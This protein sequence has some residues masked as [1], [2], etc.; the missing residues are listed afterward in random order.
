MMRLDSL[1]IKNYR[2]LEN[3]RL[4]FTGPITILIGPNNVGKSNI[5]DALLFIQTAVSNLAVAIGQR[6]GFLRIA[7]G[8][9]PANT[10]GFDLGLSAPE[11]PKLEYSVSF[12]GSG[13]LQERVVRAGSP[14]YEAKASPG[15]MMVTQGVSFPRNGSLLILR[16]PEVEPI[17]QFL[18]GVVQV[19]P[20]R[21]VSIQSPIG[22]TKTIQPTGLDLAQVL[23]YHY[24]GDQEGFAAFQ[25]AASK[26]LPE[27]DIIETPIVGPAATTVQLRLKYDRTKYD[28]SEISSGIKGILVLL[29]AA[30]FSSRGS[31]I[32]IEEPENHIHPAAQKALCSVLKEVATTQ[33]KQFILTTH[34]DSVLGQFDPDHCYFV[35]RTESG[36]S[37][38]PLDKMDAYTIGERLGVERGLLLQVLGR[39]QQ[40][41]V[42]CEGR[43]DTKVIESLCRENDLADAVL[44]AR[45]SGGGWKEIVD[46]AADLRDALKRFRI[47]SSVFV[48]LDNDGESQAKLAYLQSKG[49]GEETAHV[50]FQKEIESYLALPATLATLSRKSLDEIQQV[51]RSAPGSGKARLHWILDRLGIADIP[52]SVIVTNA[53]RQTTPEI[54]EEFQKIVAKL[55]A[56]VGST[57]P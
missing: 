31:L 57:A 20:F 46:S 6:R 51:I 16:T 23:H 26:V 27:L 8:Q 21:N 45:A 17:V 10:I 33:D 18:S 4:D 3:I 55:R 49:F 53:A 52:P 34:S 7:R 40:I 28:L 9:N 43:T 14:I 12:D 41:V 32:L 24:N 39:A 35:D 56:L 54:P 29:A 25:A 36:S 30:H 42:I 19:D 11:Q 22:P 44:P 48:L 15:N 13:M 47:H 38:T 5:V 37:A 2:L 1:Q 50:W